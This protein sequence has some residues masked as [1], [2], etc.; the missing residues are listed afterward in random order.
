V[1]IA[2]ALAVNPPL[3]MLDEPTASLDS[4]R[5]A[6]LGALLRRL[7]GDERTVLIT[8]HDES[9]ASEWSTGVLRIRNGRIE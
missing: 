8:T 4:A 7:A 5:R 6:G 2:R 3:L 9:F 1:A